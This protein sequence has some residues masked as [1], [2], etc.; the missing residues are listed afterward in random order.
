LKKLDYKFKIYAAVKLSFPEFN[1][2]CFVNVP[3]EDI[4]DEPKAKDKVGRDAEIAGK[5]SKIF[6]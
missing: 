1:K 4:Y 6:I 5:F 2:T 3:N